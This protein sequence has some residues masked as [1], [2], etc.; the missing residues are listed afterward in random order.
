MDIWCRIATVDVEC[1]LLSVDVNCIAEEPPT[2]E[3][4]AYA[5]N[6]K[7]DYNND[8]YPNYDYGTNQIKSKSNLS[9]Y[10]L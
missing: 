10:S 6:Y 3:T 5:A 1:E 7:Y 2:P 8:D 4:P 9:L